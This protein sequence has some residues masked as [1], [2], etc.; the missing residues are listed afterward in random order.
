[1]LNHILPCLIPRDVS[2]KGDVIQVGITNYRLPFNHSSSTYMILIWAILHRWCYNYYASGYI[3]GSDTSCIST[4]NMDEFTLD[5]RKQ[6]D[7][8]LFN[9]TRTRTKYV[10]FAVVSICITRKCDINRRE[11]Q[12]CSLH[13][14]WWQLISAWILGRTPCCSP[15][16]SRFLA[17]V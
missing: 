5:K 3:Y 9:K 7:S 13:S 1:M 14:R 11:F 10:E 16:L 12:L 15:L 8:E 2:E 4:N 6:W 17:L